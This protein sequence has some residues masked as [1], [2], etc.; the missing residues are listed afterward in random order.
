[1]PTNEPEVFKKFFLEGLINLYD[2]RDYCTFNINFQKPW[3][4][5]EYKWYT[6]NIRDMGFNINSKYNY[7]YNFE[8]NRVP[9]NMIRHDSIIDYD[10]MYYSLLDD[11]MKF[12]GTSR[13]NTM[14]IGHQYLCSL[15][16]LLDHDDCGIMIMGGSSSRV[17]K[18]YHISTINPYYPYATGLGMAVKSL[19]NIP[20]YKDNKSP[21]L[22][23]DSLHLVG[24]SEEKV[25]AGARLIC[26]L[27]PARMVGARVSHHENNEKSGFEGSST[28]LGLSGQDM[29]H[30]HDDELVNENNHG[31]IR[32]N[33]L[34]GKDK[35]RSILRGNVASM[36]LYLDNGGSEDYLL[37]PNP[38]DRNYENSVVSELVDSINKRL[39]LI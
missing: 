15:D 3:T 35:N 19:K 18:K 39:L 26:G 4:T 23:D 10:G 20:R 29:Y 22:P 16:Y 12:K 38:T 17:P 2:F 25:I 30:W 6:D 37:S 28:R 8:N 36:C 34:V 21:L 7:E 32:D 27:N 9:I 14:N 31:Y 11:D 1:M 5:Y 13:G 33:Y 24:G